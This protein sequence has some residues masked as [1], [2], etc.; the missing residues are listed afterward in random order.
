ME[1]SLIPEDFIKA[2]LENHYKRLLS[3]S[4]LV[5]CNNS[6]TKFFSL[7][8]EIDQQQKDKSNELTN[9]GSTSSTN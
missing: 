6:I 7:L 4:E 5:E 3:D 1:Y 2:Y 9:N 8:M